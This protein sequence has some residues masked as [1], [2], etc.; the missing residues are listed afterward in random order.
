MIVV[1]FTTRAGREGEIFVSTAHD[2][3]GIGVG[4]NNSFYSVDTNCN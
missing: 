3:V 1:Y 2:V 4:T